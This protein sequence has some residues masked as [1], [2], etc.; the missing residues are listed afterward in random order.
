[1]QHRNAAGVPAAEVAVV[2]LCHDLNDQLAAVSAYTYLLNRRGVLGDIG[3]PL[4]KQL[5][6]IAETIGLV[7][8]LARS[9]D[10][11]VGPVALSLLS[12]TATVIMRGYPQGRVVFEVLDDDSP[13]VIRCDWTRALRALLAAGAWVSREYV[14]SV[15][16]HVALESA[17]E[18]PTLR[19]EAV[20]D[21][22]TPSPS[23]GLPELSDDLVVVASAGRSLRFRLA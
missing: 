21:L 7:R 22:P 14:E 15:T 17:T 1:M 2:G 12:E 9:H 16:V 8:S 6:R 10:A 19:V 5:D 11:S 18:G 3:D 20:G 13:A 4:Q 23:E